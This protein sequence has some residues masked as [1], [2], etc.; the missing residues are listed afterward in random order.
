MVGHHTFLTRYVV[1]IR[2]Y[3]YPYSSLAGNY[4]G[5]G[6]LW[7]H[8]FGIQLALYSIAKLKVDQNFLPNFQLPIPNQGEFDC[9]APG[10]G[11]WI[12]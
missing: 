10:F 7:L 3:K 2:T 5:S 11:T 8:R 12:V 6:T 9:P 4:L 1:G